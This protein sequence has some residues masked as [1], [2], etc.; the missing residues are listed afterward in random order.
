MKE[1]STPS[2]ALGRTQHALHSHNFKRQLSMM[3]YIYLHL[4]KCIK[5]R[6]GA[7]RKSSF[8]R[9]VSSGSETGDK[10]KNVANEAEREKEENSDKTEKRFEREACEGGDEWWWWVKLIQNNINNHGKSEV[11]QLYLFLLPLSLWHEI[12]YLIL[13]ILTQ[14]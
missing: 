3:E 13:L 4:I 8:S 11:L 12:C 10:R 14:A 1:Y 2:L 7:E 6:S 5:N 9:R